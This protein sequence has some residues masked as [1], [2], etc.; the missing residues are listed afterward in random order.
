MTR[1]YRRRKAGTQEN[2]R[3]GLVAGALATSVAGDRPWRPWLLAPVIALAVLYHQ[4][5]VLFV[6]PLLVLLKPG[7]EDP[8]AGTVWWKAVAAMTAGETGGS[9]T[10]LPVSTWMSCRSNS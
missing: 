10:T 1:Y 8:R 4:T 7:R 3:A 9:P 2:L 6:V 5:N